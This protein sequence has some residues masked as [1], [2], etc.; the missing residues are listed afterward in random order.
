M[1]NVGNLGTHSMK[2]FT[3]YRLLDRVVKQIFSKKCYKKPMLG[4]YFEDQDGIGT[5]RG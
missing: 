5:R 3:F 4:A 2:R 1:R